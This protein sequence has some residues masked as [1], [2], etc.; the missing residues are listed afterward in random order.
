MLR[1]FHTTSAAILLAL[2]LPLMACD[3][4]K[5]E[6]DV[7]VGPSGDR[8]V[9][10][11]VNTLVIPATTLPFQIMPVLG[12]PSAPP[13]ASHFS[14]V[15]NPISVDLTMTEV[16]LQFVDT[17]GIVSPVNF[18]QT[19]LRVLFGSTTIIAGVGRTFP[20]T[21]NFGCS[22][23]ARPRVMRGRAVFVNPHGRRVEQTFEGRFGN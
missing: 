2:S 12:C 22:F 17:A 3:D 13:F 8:F 4:I 6:D 21:T 16:G 18:G 11:A 15:V 5:L 10:P 20:F 23:S 14:L 19:D 7:L 9:T 1:S